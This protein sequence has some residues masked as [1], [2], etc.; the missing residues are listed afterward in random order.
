MDP[1]KDQEYFWGLRRSVVL[2]F[3]IWD[4]REKAASQRCRKETEKK[5]KG[6]WAS[7][8]SHKL[9]VFQMVK[10]FLQC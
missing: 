4:Q 2:E 1:G 10:G 5:T 8:D 7:E 6:C 3:G 9:K